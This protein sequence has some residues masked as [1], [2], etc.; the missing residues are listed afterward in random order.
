[1]FIGVSASTSASSLPND[2]EKGSSLEVDGEDSDTEDASQE[3]SPDN[4]EADGEESDIEDASQQEQ[5]HDNLEA[6]HEDSVIDGAS[7]RDPQQQQR[8]GLPEVSSVRRRPLKGYD[9]NS[10]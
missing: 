6:D 10:D 9:V 3:Q 1:M 2:L 4:L 7:Q 5:S 8:G